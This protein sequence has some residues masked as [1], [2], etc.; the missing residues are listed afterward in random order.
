MGS[1]IS[2][3]YI[4]KMTKKHDTM[5]KV[6]IEPQLY[7]CQV[8]EDFKLQVEFSTSLW[9]SSYIFIADDWLTN[10]TCKNSTCIRFSSD[11]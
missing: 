8:C 10:K 5:G 11:I 3:S 4:R 1:K 7:L 2:K 9:G 6:T